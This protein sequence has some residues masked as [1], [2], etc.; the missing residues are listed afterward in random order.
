MTNREIVKRNIT[1]ENPPRFGIKF[2]AFDFNDCY[3]IW[4]RDLCDY[5]AARGGRD[6]WGCVWQRSEMDNM[7]RI[8]HHPLASWPDYDSYQFPDPDSPAKYVNFERDMTG[9]GDRF[10][11]FCGG[12][13]LFERFHTLRGFEAAL[14]DLYT[15][16]DRTHEL[17]DR[18]LDFHMRAIS[19]AHGLGQGRIDAVAISDDWGTELATIISPDK[20]REFFKPRYVKLFRHIHDL[21]MHTWLHSCGKINEVLHDLI[22]AGLE[23]VNMQQPRTVGIDEV[24]R[25]F[26]GRICF[27]TIVDIQTTY[28][29]GTYDEI[30]AEA[31]ELVEKWNTP[32]GGFIASDYN[33]AAAIGTTLERRRVA[34]EAF[35][36]LAGLKVS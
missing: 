24:S 28:P 12:L 13:G 20:F 36:R 6:E 16:P 2:D 18:I 9:A 1:F 31:R 25:C 35:A 30:R 34:F 3:D 17:V 5:D 7:G 8:S 32:R 29:G 27:E 22:E 19:G 11:M 4:L 14:V 33:D 10:V 23:V 15:E 21:G 26:A